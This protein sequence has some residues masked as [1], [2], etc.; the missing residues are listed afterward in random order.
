MADIRC[1]H[2]TAAS[3]SFVTGGT[4]SRLYKALEAAKLCGFNA[5]RLPFYFDSYAPSQYGSR[6]INYTI[7][8]EA[9]EMVRDFNF[10]YLMMTIGAGA[11]EGYV[12]PG[13]NWG[14]PKVDSVAMAANLAL[15]RDCINRV[16]LT[17]PQDRFFLQF[18][19]EMANST[20]E[21]NA[22]A[23]AK[24]ATAMTNAS[25]PQITVTAH[26]L[27]VGDKV[28]HYSFPSSGANGEWVVRQVVD[29]NNYTT[30]YADGTAAPA[31]GG[32]NVSGSQ[33]WKQP[34]VYDW[35]HE[36]FGGNVEWFRNMYPM[37]TTM[38]SQFQAFP[39]TPYG[40]DVNESLIDFNTYPYQESIDVF[41][42]SMYVANNSRAY[43]YGGDF[44]RA[45]DLG[46]RKALQYQAAWDRLG[47]TDKELCA[48]EIGASFIAAGMGTASQPQFYCRDQERLGDFRAGLYAQEEQNNT[49]PLPNG[50]NGFVS[51]FC[52]INLQSG[53]DSGSDTQHHGL[54][55][56]ANGKLYRN[57]QQIAYANGVTL[58][59]GYS[60]E[61]N[62]T[63]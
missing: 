55:S 44:R 62:P 20:F 43:G 47:T 23:S 7:L 61:T 17:F 12:T 25:P 15:Q 2:A 30:E 34:T 36:L 3:T 5:V 26:G 52:A 51:Y 45:Y 27:S 58:P 60:Y 33:V 16:M 6:G 24:S 29:A 63:N 32:T 53:W 13:G 9:I 4:S 1:I 37:A 40:S 19:N 11:G 38:F 18:G 54:S 56:Y 48:I 41:G 49:T 10:P 31:P 57:A 46:R 50:R 35:Q 42:Y 28:V 39:S 14:N 22:Y 59:Q 8:D 21:G